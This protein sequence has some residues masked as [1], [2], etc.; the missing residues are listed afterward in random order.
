MDICQLISITV[1]NIAEE[2]VDYYTWSLYYGVHFI[3][4][5]NIIHFNEILGYLLTMCLLKSSIG[6]IID[7]FDPLL[8]FNHSTIYIG[9]IV[10]YFLALSFCCCTKAYCAKCVGCNE[11]KGKKNLIWLYMKCID[12]R[13]WLNMN[14]FCFLSSTEL[15]RKVIL[16]SKARFSFLYIC[17]HSK[18]FWFSI[19]SYISTMMRFLDMICNYFLPCI[20]SD[21]FI[22]SE[23]SN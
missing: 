15:C 22:L 21:M 17:A 1:V 5:T 3:A 2:L 6:N 19:L 16:W 7:I 8:E 11:F 14:L 4:F 12:T 23:V 13:S 9:S 20:F 10:Y 18:R